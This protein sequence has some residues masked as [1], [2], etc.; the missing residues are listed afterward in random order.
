MCH[1]NMMKCTVRIAKQGDISTMHA[2]RLAVRE[3][4]L[5]AAS[6]ITEAS[7]SPYVRGG[8]AWVAE[9]GDKI[10][11][12]AAADPLSGNVW[13]MFVAPEA[14]GNG[15]GR[16]LHEAVLEW[17]S[18]LGIER[19]NLTTAAET[20]AEHFYRKMGWRMTGHHEDGQVC[21]DRSPSR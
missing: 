5:G 9:L 6:G 15:I 21:F 7:Y 2:I 4:S 3:N 8:S 19:I 10:F 16:A 20:R 13:A 11:G 18:C 12:F 17:A 14:E 1:H